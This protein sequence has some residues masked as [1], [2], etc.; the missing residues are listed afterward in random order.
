V[1]E[2]N[3]QNQ[4]YVHLAEECGMRQQSATLTHHTSYNRVMASAL[5]C[6]P[7][8]AHSVSSQMSEIQIQEGPCRYMNEIALVVLR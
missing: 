4:R 7:K 1:I 8:R 5:I 2:A 3:G 6:S